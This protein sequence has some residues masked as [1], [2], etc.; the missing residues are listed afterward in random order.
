MMKKPEKNKVLVLG[1]DDRSALTVIRSLGRKKITVHLGC[2]VPSSICRYSKYTKKVFSFPDAGK[3]PE[4]WLEELRKRL[5]QER[6]DLVIPTA[7]NYLVLIVRNRDKLEKLAKLA[8]PSDKGFIYTYNKS[9]TFELARSLGVPCPKTKK[10]DHIESIEQIV[11]EFSFPMI[12]KPVSSKVWQNNTRHS[13]NVELAKDRKELELK[14]SRVLRFCPVLIQSFHEGIGV[15][16]ELLMNKGSLVAAFQHERIHEPM[17]GGG[18][19]YRKS[20][21]P[22]PGLLRHSL[23]MMK[24]LEWTGVAMVEYKYD[25]E[26]RES[27]LMEINGRFWGSLPLAVVAGVDFPALL[28]DLMMHNK[29]PKKPA[30]KKDIYCR[31]IT[32]DLDWF[33]ENL[34]A[35]KTDPLKITVPVSVLLK[36]VKNIITFRERFDTL[37]YD[38]LYPGVVHIAR[39]L[40]EKLK[41]ARNKLQ[42][43]YFRI[44]HGLNI[45]AILNHRRK[46]KKLLKIN[47]SVLFICKGNICRSPFAEL[48]L[49]FLLRQK[50]IEVE[51]TGLIKKTMR[52]SPE[53]AVEAARSFGVDLTEHRSKTLS[54]EVIDK[55]GILIVMDTD[56]FQKIKL[57]YP[58]AENKLF[59]LGQMQKGFPKQ[60]EIFDPYGQSVNRFKEIY[61][62]I[63][64]SLE[65]LTDIIQ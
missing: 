36:E 21:E 20:A 15:G 47:P 16:Q 48:Y 44:N 65:G 23:D 61:K 10:T 35:D 46:I 50:H 17:K 25:K 31:N 19:S 63:T 57:L 6:Y 49:K 5:I 45:I 54:Q 30:F 51:S 42:K 27:V 39:Y 32:R 60:V 43:I 59:F 58:G 26:T 9:K 28:F 4:L 34:T 53:N 14:L 56:Q 62:L 33:K 41:S 37:V 24:E 29:M 40:I 7:D 52:K 3:E 2:D 55:F 38:D 8:V 11:K 18:S 1:V 12:V 64:Q 22:D 13:L